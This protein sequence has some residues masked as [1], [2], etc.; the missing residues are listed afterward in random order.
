M[1][2]GFPNPVLGSYPRTIPVGGSSRLRGGLKVV[3]LE[4]VEPSAG[5]SVTRDRHAAL[6]PQ[7]TKG[8]HPNSDIGGWP[9]V[10]M[11]IAASHT[12]DMMSRVN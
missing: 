8:Q 7:R 12:C 6:A 4:G 3:E 2:S 9:F 5:I 10:F 11:S 1:N